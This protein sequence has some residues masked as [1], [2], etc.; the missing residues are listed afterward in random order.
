VLAAGS[1]EEVAVETIRAGADIFLI[2]HNQELVWR[3]YEAVL[4]EAE[5]D[6]KFAARVSQAAASV[7]KFKRRSREL[8]YFT[9]RPKTRV[10]ETIKKVMQD[11]SQIIEEHPV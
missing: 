2:C 1:I 4:R 11:Y 10:L 3:G 9:A 7:L 8:H 6:R 5:K